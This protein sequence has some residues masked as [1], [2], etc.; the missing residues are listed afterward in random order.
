MITELLNNDHNQYNKYKQYNKIK[1]V[2]SDTDR[3]FQ[4]CHYN[5][6]RLSKTKSVLKN[7]SYKG[8]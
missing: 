4:Q 1:V 7:K 6:A 8:K 3:K 2:F 5:Q